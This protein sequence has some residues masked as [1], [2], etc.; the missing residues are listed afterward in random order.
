MLQTE[1]NYPYPTHI[2]SNEQYAR[3]SLVPVWMY[4]QN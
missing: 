2:L 1:G 3:V 4:Q